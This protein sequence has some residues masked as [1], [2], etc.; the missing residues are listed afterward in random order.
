MTG[1]SVVSNHQ[2]RGVH[3]WPGHTRGHGRPHVDARARRYTILT[4]IRTSVQLDGERA[5]HR[6]PCTDP[7]CRDARRSASAANRMFRVG[8][9]E[10]TAASAV[11]VL[12][13]PPDPL[14]AAWRRRVLHPRSG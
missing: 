10:F 5:P 11:A 7:A 3:H 13:R 9:L 12:S 14:I 6:L 8:V 1:K 2:H 4:R